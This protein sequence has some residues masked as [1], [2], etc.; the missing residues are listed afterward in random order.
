MSPRLAEN[1]I[2]CYNPWAVKGWFTEEKN[3]EA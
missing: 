2:V 1:H 3:D